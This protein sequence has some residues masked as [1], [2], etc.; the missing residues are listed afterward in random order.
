MPLLKVLCLWTNLVQINKENV[1]APYKITY[2]WTTLSSGRSIWKIV[3][4]CRVVSC[5]FGWFNGWLGYG[6]PAAAV[7]FWLNGYCCIA[8]EEDGKILEREE[9]PVWGGFTGPKR[10]QTRTGTLWGHRQAL[11]IMPCHHFYGVFAKVWDFKHFGWK[12]C[13][14]LCKG[15]E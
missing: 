11:A 8:I 10:P 6:K 3:W 2:G 14:F 4:V 15:K 13:P 1:R 9:T 7:Y 5:L 12:N